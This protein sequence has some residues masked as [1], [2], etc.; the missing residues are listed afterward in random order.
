ML[1]I[2]HVAAYVTVIALLAGAILHVQAF[3]PGNEH[4]GRRW[5]RTDQPVADGDIARTWIWGPEANTGVVTEAYAESPDGQRQVQYY[6]KSRMEINDPNGD[7]NV[8]L[9]RHQ[10][11]ARHRTDDRQAAVG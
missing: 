10:R 8:A 2:T 1:R 4:F 6:D 9:L 11:P 3:E 5:A 7:P